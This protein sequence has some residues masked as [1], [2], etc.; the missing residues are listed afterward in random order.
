MTLRVYLHVGTPKSGTT[1][2][3]G[4]LAANRDALSDAGVKVVGESHLDLVH[5]GLVVR[6][7]PRLDR[8]PP[9]ARAAWNRVVDDVRAWRGDSAIVSYELL[10]GATADQ[11]ARAI[12]D[13]APAE[14]HVVVTA[15]DFARALPS[16]WQERLK[17]G[18]VTPLEAW[19]PPPE[20]DQRSEWGWRTLDPAGVIRR[21]GARL[22]PE[23][24]HLVTA[25]PGQP[26]DQLWSRF[27]DA[28]DLS[29]VAILPADMPANTSLG[30]GPAEVL[31]RV[32]E[33]VTEPVTGNREQ[34]VWLRD[35]LAHRVL[36]P[37]DRET[38]GL[39]DELFDTACARA[40]ESMAQLTSS[41]V[42]WHGS[43]DDLVPRRPTGRTP[44]QVPQAELL[45][46]A[47][48]AIWSLLLE[49][50]TD[51]HNQRDLSGG[52]PA[53]RSRFRQV[54]KNLVVGVYAQRAQKVNDR[55][56]KRM[57][58]LEADLAASRQL[59]L[60]LAAVTDVVEELLLPG[61]DRDGEL[62]RSAVAAYRLES[63]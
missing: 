35:L 43:P 60:R 56:M 32:N 4:I 7:D 51:R 38:I 50:R 11:A 9:R 20:S 3:Q 15:R 63:M 42:Q 19:Q 37:L 17:F 52:P 62:L 59:E 23:Q 1:Y 26:P 31:R 61:L 16:A 41:G 49:L 28:C 34:S 25:A 40:S 39:S 18:L 57:T 13:L 5:A 6:E 45:D 30:A 8:L 36:A 14:V 10:A 12:E 22:P 53:D 55:L 47:V 58:Q 27:A 24:V 54:A 48:Q 2:L 44:G 46:V 29:G 21:W 33:L